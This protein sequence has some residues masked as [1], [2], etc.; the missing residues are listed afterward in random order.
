MAQ[1]GAHPLN[2]TKENLV[3]LQEMGLVFT[4]QTIF[5]NFNNVKKIVLGFFLGFFSS[6]FLTEP[7]K[8]SKKTEDLAGITVF[9]IG[10]FFP[11]LNIDILTA[12]SNLGEL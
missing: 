8:E 9:H 12:G 7:S 11:S 4:T 2:Q 6:F 5:K 3:E 10:F 1:H